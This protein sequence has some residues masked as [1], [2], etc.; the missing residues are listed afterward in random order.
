MAA[1]ES[2]DQF[3][4]DISIN[5]KVL[6]VFPEGRRVLITCY[7]TQMPLPITYTLWDS[8]GTEL[9]MAVLTRHS[10]SFILN[11]TLKSSP[12]LL[13]YS[14]HG[15]STSGKMAISN[16]LQMFKEL[17]DMLL[18]QLQANFTMMEGPGVMVEVICQVSLGS[19]PITY[20]PVG[21]TGCI[22]EEQTPPHGEPANFSFPQAEMSPNS[23]TPASPQVKLFQ[24][25][26]L[27]LAGSLT[28]TA[29]ASGMLLG[30]ILWICPP[31]P[32][33]VGC[34]DGKI[35]RAEPPGQPSACPTDGRTSREGKMSSLI[36]DA[37]DAFRNTALLL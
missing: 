19:P 27:V 37:P 6:E 36:L 22:H 11:T 30:C 18:S 24:G 34:C 15:A 33:F 21:K 2:G 31:F 14:C 9:G 7:S 10:G 4:F 20:R 8:Q 17:W 1:A 5:Y 13:T 3:T 35:Q 25:P 23:A 28:G 29:F 26:T 32:L 12:V 16:S